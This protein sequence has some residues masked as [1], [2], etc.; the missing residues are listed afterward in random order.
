[1][2]PE[3]VKKLLGELPQGVSLVGAAKTR[4]PDEILEAIIRLSKVS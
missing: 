4:M 1:M 2:I 3:Q